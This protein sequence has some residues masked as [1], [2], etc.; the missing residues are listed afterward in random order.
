M[1]KSALEARANVA[2]RKLFEDADTAFNEAFVSLRAEDYRNAAGLFDK[3]VEL[4]RQCRNGA[5]EKRVK[6]EEAIRRAEQTLSEQ[7]AAASRRGQPD[8]EENK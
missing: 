5:I 8:K 2:V 1:R 4:F 6:A 7:E 3:A